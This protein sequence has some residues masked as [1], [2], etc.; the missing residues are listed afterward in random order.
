MKR[1]INFILIG[2]ILWAFTLNAQQR[3]E[4]KYTPRDNQTTTTPKKLAAGALEYY[5]LVRGTPTPELIWNAHKQADLLNSS[6]SLTW[7]E[8]GPN[9]KAGRTRAILID[10][11]NPNIIYAGGVSGGL[12]RSTDGGASWTLIF[13]TAENYAISALAQDIN[14][15]IYVGTGEG[16]GVVSG[17]ANGGTSF[18]GNGI[19][20]ST[21]ATGTSFVHLSSTT[22]TSLTSPWIYVNELA[23]STNS[24]RIYAATYKGLYKS[25]DGG[26]TWENIVYYPGSSPYVAEA[27]DVEVASNGYVYAVVGGKIFFSTSGDVNTFSN[28]TIPNL[29]NSSRIEIAVAPSDPNYVYAVV[30]AT[31]GSLKGVYRTTDAGTTWELIGPGGSQNFNL[32]GSNNQGRW[33]NTVVVYPN[34]K[35][36]IL[37]GGIDLWVYEYNGN[38]IQKTLWYLSEASPYYLHADHHDIKFHPTNPN[39]VYHASDG[40][41]SISTDGG[42]TWQTRNRNYST[43]QFYYL[44]ANCFNQLLGGTQDNG[45]LLMPNYPSN[46]KQAFD[47]IGGDGGWAAM[48]YINPEVIVGTMYYGDAYRDDE[49]G[50]NPRSIYDTKLSNISP[51][52]GNPGYA[53]FV[54]PLLLDEKLWDFYSQDSVYFKAD[55]NYHAGDTVTVKS[56]NNNYP[57]PYVLPISLNA[58][59]SILVQDIVTARFYIGLKNAVWMTKEIHN[60]G[61]APKWI[62]I[63]SVS[64]YP[65]SMAIS[66]DGNYLFV[67]T[68]EGKLYRISNLLFVKDSINGDI[69]SPYCVVETKEIASHTNRAITSIA[70]DPSDPNKLLYTL[71]KYGEN[72]YVFYST[73]ALSQTPTFTNKTG[74]LPKM[75]VYASLIEMHNSNYVMLGTELG[76]FVTTNI[77]ASSPTWEEANNGLGRVPVYSLKQQTWN[78]PGATN[79]G[80]IYAGTHGRGAF[81]CEQFVSLNDQP[82]QISPDVLTI[83]PNPAHEN[84]RI[85]FPTSEETIVEVIT[86]NVTGQLVMNK[87]FRTG[88]GNTMILLPVNHLPE[89]LYTV[90]IKI[91]GKTL[92]GKFV[93]N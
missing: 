62:Q 68:S 13:P 50:T 83:F 59:D 42:N 44:T 90:Q 65:Q 87:I 39:I 49:F 66:S 30:A 81:K 46:T 34:N 67:G 61:R 40:G 11:N 72:Q 5:E 15:I 76:V 82:T 52:P 54:T 89:G 10:R 23:T 85:S 78:Y 88:A 45:T 36:K 8:L 38:W 80:V 84:V 1:Y 70:S 92:T 48:S 22:P 41:V 53:S 57:F 69:S 9:N 21:D 28:I 77:N 37:V 16:F 75:P 27:Q 32:F 79:Y 35:N 18:I 31:N 71:G 74:N 6:K 7:N 14:G 64:G 24:T 47:Y 55:T 86:Y 19:Y 12:W 25:D 51:K 2:T 73:N 93:K 4:K 63:A 56:K 58:G 60:F 3:H 91:K 20:K 26:Q 33:D 17:S 29:G 43:I